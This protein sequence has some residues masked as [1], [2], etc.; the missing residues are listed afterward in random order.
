MK[1]IKWSNIFLALCY[2]VA[3][4]FFFIDP[5]ISKEIICTWMGYGLL[6]IGVIYIISY[7]VRSK[8]ESRFKN[9][10]R[11]GLILLTLGTLA[12]VKR[13][14]FLDI[15]YFIIAIVI[16]IS[17]YKKLQDLVDA[18][19][20]NAEHNLL[21]FILAAISIA[22][23]LIIIFDTTIDNKPLH[24]LIAGGLL[25][26]GVSDLISDIFLAAKMSKY[27]NEIN[28]KEEEKQAQASIVDEV[29]EEEPV[30][31]E[32]VKATEVL[33]DENKNIED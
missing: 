12:L 4:V 7:F 22:V 21:Y 25:Y 32:E 23:G 19:R 3:G 16:M 15:I 6:T 24:Y 8:Q 17:G 27:I 1:K 2:I 31:E 29:V 13:I 28:K 5:N 20:L 18:W 10:F 30:Q 33:E 11:D 26:S 9:E 14:L